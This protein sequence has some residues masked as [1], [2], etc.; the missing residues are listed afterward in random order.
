MYNNI[1][2]ESINKYGSPIYFNEIDEIDFKTLAAKIKINDYEFSKSII[3]S[4]CKGNFIL[5]K[6]AFSNEFVKNLKEEVKKFWKNNPESFSKIIDG[7]K[8]F[9]RSIN[10]EIAKNYSVNAVKHST[11]FFPWNHDPCKCN[12]LIYEKWDMVKKISGFKK[13]QFRNNLPKDLIIDRIQVAVYPPGFGELEVH[14]DPINNTKIATNIYLSSYKNGDF[15]SGG[16]YFL[17]KNK[18]QINIEKH[19]DVGDMGMFY[20]NIMHGV[21]AIDKHLIENIKNYE[22]N[23]GVGRWFLGLNTIDSDLHPNR[24]TT[25][26]K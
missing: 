22:W 13:G 20:G 7:C 4:L 24:T 8:D 21:N 11:F 19:I 23:S 15:E 10:P 25:V 16:F 9:H 26:P 12:Q 6:N 5:I 18:E 1:W 17:N 2:K 14:T 3:E